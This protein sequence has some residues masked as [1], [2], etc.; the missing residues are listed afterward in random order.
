MITINDNF[1]QRLAKKLLE[2]VDD[3]EFFNG[4]VEL[5]GEDFYATLK[6]TL[7]IYRRKIEQQQTIITPIEKIV[8]VWWELSLSTEQGE[9]MSDFSWWDLRDY[10][11]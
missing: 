5:D 7:V 6:T 3:K 8:P 10:L 1:Y 2:A 4:S 9:Q 11:P